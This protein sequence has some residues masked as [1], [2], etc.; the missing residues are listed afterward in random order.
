MRGREDFGVEEIIFG[1]NRPNIEKLVCGQS[2]RDAELEVVGRESGGP[3][4]VRRF[5]RTIESQNAMNASDLRFPE[6]G[7]FELA[8]GA[9]F[10]S[11]AMDDFARE[12]R[13]ESSGFGARARGIRENVEIGERK[14]IDEAKSCFVIRFGF[15]GESGDNVST[16]GSVRKE[17]PDEL[18][19]ASVVLR[20]IPTVHSSKNIVRAG[21]QRHVKVPGDAF[22][23]GKKG[24]EVHGD[25][26]RLDG[27]DAQAREWCFVKNAAQ[28]IEDVGAGREVASPG[29]EIDT[30]EYDFLKAGGVEAADF[31]EDGFG[32]EAAALSAYERYDAEGAAIVAAIL[33]FQGRASVIPFSAEDWSDEDVACGEDVAGK[34][35][36]T[37][38]D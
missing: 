26:E 27:A 10:A 31:R 1:G 29:A 25:I 7:G 37:T 18:H 12:L 4:S 21:L 19:A 17:L 30:A 8:E 33:N 23:A 36:S 38:W 5:L 32:R 2:F 20:A 9:K 11:T 28:E 13:L 16:D 24:D 15:A 6:G 3:G 34:D 22:C 14:R 35:C